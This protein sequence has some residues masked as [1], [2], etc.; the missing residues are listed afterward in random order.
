MNVSAI[1]SQ[2][3]A[4]DS[5]EYVLTVI[6]ALI[7]DVMEDNAGDI[8]TDDWAASFFYLNT[9]KRMV[10]QN[11]ADNGVEFNLKET[12]LTPLPPVANGGDPSIQVSITQEG[13]FD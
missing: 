3:N 10:E 11:L 7:N 4:Y 12:V 8:F 5:V 2:G 9:A 6:R 1:V 13:Y